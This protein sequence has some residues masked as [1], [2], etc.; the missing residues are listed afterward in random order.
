MVKGMALGHVLHAFT[1]PARIWALVRPDDQLQLVCL[2]ETLQT[3]QVAACIEERLLWQ[4]FR[5]CCP[6]L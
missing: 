3:V 4:R 1:L 2:E 5:F 6:I